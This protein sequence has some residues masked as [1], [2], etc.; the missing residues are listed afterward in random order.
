MLKKIN[1]VAPVY[2]EEA[3]IS[4]F[5]EAL[6]SILDSMKE[7]YNFEVIYVLDKC[8]D[9]TISILKQLSEQNENIKVVALSSRFGHQMSLVAGMDRCDGD[10]VIM[11]DS[12][13]QHPPAVIPSLLNK[14]EEGYNIVH[15]NR[16]TVE[17]ISFIRALASKWFYWFINYISSVNMGANS[18]DFRLISKEVLTVFKN[19]IRE[20]N[21]FL[22]GLFH[23]VGF[24]DTVVSF[25]AAQRTKGK[26]KYNILRL[27]TFAID[28]IVS[29]SKTPLKLSVFIGFIMSVASFLHG[30]FALVVFL[31]N[32]TLPSGWTT[33]VVLIS[34]IGGLQLIF[35][36]IIGEYIAG[37]FDE[38]KKR[39]LYI[40]E[41]EY[42]YE[43]RLK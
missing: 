26:S 25:E 24:N 23:W 16:I 29:F 2:N 28:G 27:I 12:D 19:Q 35:L 7:K 34:F 8:T 9:N 40:V 18:A 15:T 13:L 36:G 31:M 1:I 21:Q 32:K 11:M 22:R 42:G 37:I 5:N 14:Y 39:P 10:A 43:K 41:K 6:F 38:V 4:D 17:D 20:H 30:I 33:L 3:V